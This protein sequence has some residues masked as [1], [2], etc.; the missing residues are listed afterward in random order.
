[1][2]KPTRPTAQQYRAIAGEIGE[3]EMRTCSSE[4]RDELSKLVALYERRA[5]G[6]VRPRA[7]ISRRDPTQ[8][9]DIEALEPEIVR[10]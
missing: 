7:R 6:P 8:G 1:M 9:R 10:A 5:I 3:I 2:S 4:V